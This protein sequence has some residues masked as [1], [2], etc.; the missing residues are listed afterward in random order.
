MCAIHVCLTKLWLQLV[1]CAV[2]GKHK[3]WDFAFAGIDAV[4][5]FEIAT[6]VLEMTT[7]EIV[8]KLAKLKSPKFFQ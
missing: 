4:K 1:N 6:Y 5:R 8:V 3:Y 7:S 2:T